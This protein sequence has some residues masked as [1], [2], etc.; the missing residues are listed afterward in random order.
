ME[1][2]DSV[3]SARARPRVCRSSR[4]SFSSNACTRNSITDRPALTQC[5]FSARRRFFGTLVASWTEVSWVLRANPRGGLSADANAEVGKGPTFLRSTEKSSR[6]F[7][8]DREATSKILQPSQGFPREPERYQASRCVPTLHSPSRSARTFVEGGYRRKRAQDQILGAQFQCSTT[9]QG[10]GEE[11]QRA[12]PV[13]WV[14]LEVIEPVCGPGRKT[15]EPPPRAAPK[16]DGVACRIYES[17]AFLHSL[18]QI[19][20]PPVVVPI[21]PQS[22]PRPGAVRLCQ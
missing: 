13:P 20:P 19:G 8:A 7:C 3:H 21:R 22:E 5:S 1:T 18:H 6:F 10:E 15:K 4:A 12:P 17:E 14:N 9:C 2:G 16:R 11:S